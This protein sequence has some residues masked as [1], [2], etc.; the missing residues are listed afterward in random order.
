MKKLLLLLSAGLTVLAACDKTENGE[1]LTRLFLADPAE[2][3]GGETVAMPTDGLVAWYPFD[4]D[5]KDASGHGHDGYINGN[6]TLT[7]GRKGAAQSA[8]YFPRDENAGIV[9]AHSDELVMDNFT[10][11]AWVFTSSG[12]YN[13]GAI[14][15]KGDYGVGTY[16]MGINYL[17]ACVTSGELNGI[18]LYGNDTD[19]PAAGKWHMLTGTVSGSKVQFYLDGKK[20]QEGNLGRNFVCAGRS[21]LVIGLSYYKGIPSSMERYPF[22]GKLDDIRIY[23]RALSATEIRTLYGE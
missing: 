5:T 16:L 10:L 22:E 1:M 21:E 15:H 9:V 19:V 17:V 12:S 14:I 6:V 4:G 8:C 2:N 11:N 13:Y 23:N 20:T 18:H 3:P 7:A